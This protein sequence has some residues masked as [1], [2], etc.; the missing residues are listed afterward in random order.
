MNPVNIYIKI[1]SGANVLTDGAGQVDG[2]NITATFGGTACI[3]GDDFESLG[4]DDTVTLIA[5]VCVEGYAF[6][7]WENAAGDNIG[8]DSSI[9]LA[10]SVVMNNIIKAVFVPVDDSLI[11]TD[12]NN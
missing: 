8:T 2:V 10:K 5:N 7:H 1:A 3:V 4:D 11:N 12:K 9:R 6:S